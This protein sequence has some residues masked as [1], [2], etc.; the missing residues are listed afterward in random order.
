MVLIESTCFFKRFV[1]GLKGFFFR[2]THKDF[3]KQLEELVN[4]QQFINHNPRLDE[5][6]QEYINKY[7][8]NCYVTT[9]NQDK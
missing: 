7:F 6:F 5:G 1:R 9:D 3:Y 4:S 8:E 2:L